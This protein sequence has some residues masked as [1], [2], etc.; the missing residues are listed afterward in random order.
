MSTS[1]KLST[2]LFCSFY[3]WKSSA[4]SSCLK[5]LRP[6][7]W[8]Y[9]RITV[10]PDVSRAHGLI[11]SYIF[12]NRLILVLILMCKV[13]HTKYSFR[14]VRNLSGTTALYVS[15]CHSC[16]QGLSQDSDSIDL[17]RELHLHLGQIVPLH[18][19][20]ASVW[21]CED[22]YTARSYESLCF[23]SITLG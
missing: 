8:L 18:H 7:D 10:M 21:T 2:A 4:A 14:D 17:E 20:L 5:T 12:K 1:I 9:N 16:A 6:A 22:L 23:M 13:N 11:K 15:M 19:M 3:C